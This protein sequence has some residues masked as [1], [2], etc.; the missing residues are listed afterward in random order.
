M[1]LIPASK[2]IEN[3]IQVYVDRLN[4]PNEIT[5]KYIVKC[6]ED[7]C[8]IL[9][10]RQK[11]VIEK[12][13][14]ENENSC[15][16]NLSK[17][18]ILKSNFSSI[19][20]IEKYLDKTLRKSEDIIHFY[21]E[22]SGNPSEEAKTWLEI[23]T[24]DIL[25]SLYNLNDKIINKAEKSKKKV[26]IENLKNN[27]EYFRVLH[28]AIQ[29]VSEAFID[30]NNYNDKSDKKTE[31]LIRLLGDACGVS[32]E[33]CILLLNGFADGAAARWRKLYEISVISSVL[34]DNDEYTSE[35]YL[36]YFHIE[37]Y[38]LL[39]KYK[40][41]PILKDDFYN[42][43]EQS[44]IE[45]Y[46]EIIRKYGNKYENNYGWAQHLFNPSDRLNFSKIQ[47][48]SN[49]TNLS[50]YYK[51]S[52][53]QVHVDSMGM[54]YKLG[55]P[56]NSQNNILFGSSS[57]GI[58]YPIELTLISILQILMIVS[59]DMNNFKAIVTGKVINKMFKATFVD[60]KSKHP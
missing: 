59:S 42:L 22:I 3:I 60:K 38:K 25:D 8:V 2:H 5:K 52:C 17:K 33:I 54:F 34:K 13:D 57:H 10:K 36:D 32:Q 14:I 21:K 50:Y 53:S 41:N 39:K 30:I 47:R 49:F 31:A 18:Q 6:L 48:I 19:N 28:L 56:K 4:N 46:N 7:Q 40:G 12:Y 15:K 51:L 9:N 20:D 43:D 55:L 37:S 11:K 1:S 26:R 35:R 23:F 29:L 27:N 45:N 58:I 24:D 16:I 44:I